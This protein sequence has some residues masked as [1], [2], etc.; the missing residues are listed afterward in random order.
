[1]S[2]TTN[3]CIFPLVNTRHTPYITLGETPCGISCQDQLDVF[4]FY[5]SKEEATLKNT[6]C[7]ISAITLSFGMF[8]FL[9]ALHERW[10]VKH[11]IRSVSFAY[12]CPFLISCGYLL[13]MFISVCPF[14][15]GAS[16]IICH[17]EERTL[18]WYSF[19]NVRC[20]LAAI[21]VYIGIRLTVFYTC[22]LSVS[23]VLTFYFPTLEQQKRYYHYV[24]WTCIF[25][26]IIAIVQTKSI[27]GDYHLG[28]CTATLSSRS[29][30]LSM[31]IIPLSICVFIFSV[32]LIF[33]TFKLVQRDKNVSKLLSV[34]T[35]MTS[36]FNRLLLYNFL[37]TASIAASVGNFCYWYINLD[38]WNDSAKLIIRCEMQKTMMQL[39]LP[40]DY[41]LC[42]LDNRD[43][44]RPPAMAFWFFHLF[45]LLSVLGAIVFQCS[46]KVRRSSINSARAIVSS[47]SGS[48]RKTISSETNTAFSQETNP[49]SSQES[50][51]SEIDG[52]MSSSTELQKLELGDMNFNEKEATKGI[53]SENVDVQM[54]FSMTAISRLTSASA[55]DHFKS[56]STIACTDYPI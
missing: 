35:H 2:N 31:D 56:N 55:L 44:P 48:I 8:Y 1:M 17:E 20:S 12:Q 10:K 34:N 36:L 32:C 14:I 21:G 22:A 18:I 54:C 43:L 23:I 38:I 7:T 45:S 41:E 3:P 33:A 27:S 5:T 9:V 37:Q 25:I 6:L 46:L 16:A 49:A 11:N 24:V 19:N 4:V 51:V 30:L 40:K 28:I 39:T 15:F 53:N 50:E 52:S 13:V 42:V 26:G 29:H 47:L